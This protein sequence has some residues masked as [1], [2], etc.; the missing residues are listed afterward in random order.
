MSTIHPTHLDGNPIQ[1]LPLSAL[2][3]PASDIVKASGLESIRQ[4]GFHHKKDFQFFFEFDAGRPSGEIRPMFPAMDAEE[5]MAEGWEHLALEVHLAVQKVTLVVR[6]Y[7]FREP[8]PLDFHLTIQQGPAGYLKDTIAI[9]DRR[10]QETE[11]SSFKDIMEIRLKSGDP[12]YAGANDI[13]GS[14]TI[15]RMI[16]ILNRYLRDWTVSHR[17]IERH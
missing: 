15:T 3:Q 6:G 4:I 12:K 9:T 17:I 11:N 10:I 16:K 1:D 5:L 13:Y 7:Y 14:M 8:V 2:L